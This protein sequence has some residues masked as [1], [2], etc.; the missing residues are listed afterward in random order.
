MDSNY[1]YTLYKTTNIIN[2]KIYIGIHKTK[3]LNDGYIGSGTYLRR[4]IKKYGIQN[5]KKEILFIFDNPHDMYAKEKEIVN[6]LFIESDI[7]Y[8]IIEG[9]NGGFEYVN[10]TKKN[11]YENIGDK[12]HGQQNLMNGR[13][14]KNYLIG[15]GLWEDW[16]KKVSIRLKEKFKKDGHPWTGRKHKSETK[17]KMSEK[18]SLRIGKLN[19]QYGTCWI[20]NTLLKI[21]KKIK[22]DELNNYIKDGWKEGRRMK[23]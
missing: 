11:L 4:A 12:T 22:N 19:S 5:F 10:I 17:K 15:K 7:S 2:N 21:N 3:D 14:V 9:G 1:K 20:Y 13:E 23:F 18:A 8:N 6:K 16:K